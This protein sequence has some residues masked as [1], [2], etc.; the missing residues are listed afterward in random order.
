MASELE[1][2]SLTLVAA[3]IAAYAQYLFKRHLKSFGLNV[4][5]MLGALLERYVLIGLVLYGLS[6]LLYIYALDKAPII[7]F[8]YPI[9]A[10][11]FV[12]V[13]LIS[14]FVLK[15]PVGFARSLGIALIIIGITAIAFTY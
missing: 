2:I 9:F 7:S 4:R 1:V 10:S 15:E 3:L 13:F 12:F 14:K 11:T 6:F 8:V 5:D